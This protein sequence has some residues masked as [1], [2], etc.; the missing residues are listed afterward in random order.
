MIIHFS[1]VGGVY[2]FTSGVPDQDG[3]CVE[4]FAEETASAW[5]AHIHTVLF[6]IERH[7]GNDVTLGRYANT[8]H[9]S[10]CLRQLAHCTGGRFHWFKGEG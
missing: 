8:S 5:N 2:I 7:V 6:D 9:T 1:V 4:A 10:E 3:G